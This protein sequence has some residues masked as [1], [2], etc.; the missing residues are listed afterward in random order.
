MSTEIIPTFIKN[1]NDFIK[2]ETPAEKHVLLTLDDDS[3][4]SGLSWLTELEKQKKFC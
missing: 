3:S 2:K 4:R 1:M